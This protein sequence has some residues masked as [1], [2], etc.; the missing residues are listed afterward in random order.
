VAK[1]K[2]IMR[3]EY[4]NAD[5][6]EL[7]A[8]SKAKTPVAKIAKLTKRTEGSL[9][10]KA[11]K[12]GISS[13][14]GPPA[15]LTRRKYSRETGHHMTLFNKVFSTRT[16]VQIICVLGAVVVMKALSAHYDF[17]WATALAAE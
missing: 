15:H 1:A 12:L 13:S 3:R 11:I 2:K 4:T 7:R 16:L 8:H 6:K 9:R 14:L 10:Q 5:V 17:S